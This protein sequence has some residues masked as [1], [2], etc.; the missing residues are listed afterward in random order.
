MSGFSYLARCFK[1]YPHAACVS[2]LF[3]FIAKQ[4]PTKLNHFSRVR[5]LVTAWTAAHQAPPSMGF[6]RQE[7]WSGVPLPLLR[8]TRRPISTNIG[9]P[10]KPSVKA[11]LKCHLLHE[12]FTDTT[13]PGHSNLRWYLCC[14]TSPLS[15]VPGTCLFVTT[16]LCSTVSV[17]LLHNN[18]C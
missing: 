7:F 4:Y 6:S 18:P 15:F 13:S 12:D 9:L 5:L 16:F 14:A 17:V 3:L 11:P 1:V 8:H 2:A 10:M